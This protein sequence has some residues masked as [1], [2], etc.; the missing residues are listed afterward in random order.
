VNVSFQFLFFRPPNRDLREAIRASR[1]RRGV[2][3]QTL[4]DGDGN[5]S[6]QVG[7]NAQNTTGHN[8][9]TPRG[10]NT[11]PPAPTTHAAKTVLIPT[12]DR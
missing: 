8:S 5:D 1:K 9:K 6:T 10:S 4:G 2:A 7:S 12:G 11:I 3:E